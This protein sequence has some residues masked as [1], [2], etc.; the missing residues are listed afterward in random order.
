[1]DEHHIKDKSKAFVTR[2][3]TQLHSLKDLYGHLSTISDEE[4]SHHV[5]AERND[6]ASWVEHVHGD[7]FL[8]QAMRRARSKEELQKA[9]FISMFR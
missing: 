2:S 1:M 7:R 6:F 4:Y 9:V 3:G 8:A 5:N